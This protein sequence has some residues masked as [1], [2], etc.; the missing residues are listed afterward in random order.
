MIGT[1]QNIRGKKVDIYLN[2]WFTSKAKKGLS[3][4]VVW[5]FDVLEAY[6]QGYK[7]RAA[8]SEH[9]D[10]GTRVF[11]PAIFY[12]KTN[13]LNVTL[14]KPSTPKPKPKGS[15]AFEDGDTMQLLDKNGVKLG[16]WTFKKE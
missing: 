16:V 12:L 1:A 2:S 4:N 8:F 10:S 15:V 9:G 7:V 13:D 11:S 6:T 14:N 3:G 5:N